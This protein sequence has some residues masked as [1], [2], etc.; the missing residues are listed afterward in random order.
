M[1]LELIERTLTVRCNDAVA[2]L[3]VAPLAQAAEREAPRVRVCFA[4]EG[5]ED[6]ASLR[7]G[8]VDLD[9]GVIDF[10]EPE[11]RTKKL[12][13]D[14]FVGVVREG[15]PM[16]A[17]NVTAQRFAAQRHIAVSRRGR[18]LGPIDEALGARGLK[19]EVMAVVTDFL[20]ALHAVARSDLVTATPESLAIAATQELA[21]ASFALPVPTPEIAVAMA[22]HPRFDD[23]P[24]HQWLRRH[25]EA[26][27][28]PYAKRGAR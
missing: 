27:V 19:R 12:I 15:H 21:V 3:L 7:D 24:A 11:L 9:I 13:T 20:A 18:A 8:R 26:W 25:V 23:E 6:A 10:L 17:K 28:K 22:W 14:R 4:Q 5:S 2:A 1:P 16:L